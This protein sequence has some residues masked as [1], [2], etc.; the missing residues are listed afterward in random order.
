MGFV[1]CKSG[2]VEI[3]LLSDGCKLAIDKEESIAGGLD[4]LDSDTDGLNGS[5]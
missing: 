5:N 4:E 3:E 1:G 2:N